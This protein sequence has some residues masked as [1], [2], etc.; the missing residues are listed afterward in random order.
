MEALAHTTFVFLV[1]NLWICSAKPL[2]F[3]FHV[4]VLKSERDIL[5]KDTD[6]HLVPRAVSKTLCPDAT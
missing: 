5:A 2:E 3:I 4:E 6:S 1:Q